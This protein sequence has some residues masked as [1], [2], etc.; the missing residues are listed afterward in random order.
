MRYAQLL[1]WRRARHIPNRCDTMACMFNTEPLR[2][3]GKP[4]PLRL[5]VRPGAPADNNPANYHFLCPIC[6]KQQDMAVGKM[7]DLVC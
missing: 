5:R 7:K 1:A 4:V 6:A 3:C 2:W